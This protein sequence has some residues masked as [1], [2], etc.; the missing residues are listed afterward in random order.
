MTS[1]TPT[2][3]FPL[4]AIIIDIP[5][6]D[7]FSYIVKGL[8]SDV[9]AVAPKNWL[10]RPP[11]KLLWWR[12]RRMTARVTT[13][14]TQ[15]NAGTLPPPRPT[16]PARP[17]K[18]PAP[19]PHEPR[20]PDPTRRVGWVLRAVPGS[21]VWASQLRDM[22]ANIKTEADY[23]RAPQLGSILRPACHMLAVR[24]PSWLRLPRRPRPPR[25]SRAKVIPPAPDWLLNSPGAILKPD[26]SIWKRFGA[27]STWTK[28]GPL[29]ETLEEAQKFDPPVRI[30]PRPE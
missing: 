16:A 12:L 21:E 20:E 1:R 14:M 5:L 10:G 29:W 17:A 13:S 25:P 2:P 19:Q 7:F 23:A 24:Q 9:V 27:S 8:L 3:T 28:P 11:I 30:W 26:G 18:P 15:L 4:V 6:A 22:F